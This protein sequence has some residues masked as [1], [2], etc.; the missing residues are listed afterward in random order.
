VPF[1]FIALRPGFMS[2]HSD[3]SGVNPMATIKTIAQ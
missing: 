2:A 1:A 3:G